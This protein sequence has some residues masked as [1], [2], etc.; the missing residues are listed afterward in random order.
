M[1]PLQVGIV[2]CGVVGAAI[3]YELSGQLN[4]AVT[5]VDQ[6]SPEQWH[7][8]GAALGVLIGALSQKL[9]GRHLQLRWDSLK[10]YETLIPELVALTGE[11]IPY[12]R[13]GILELCFDPA[14]WQRWQ[15][16]ATVRQLQGFDLQ[17]LSRE[18]VAERYPEVG[19]ARS[20]VGSGLTIGGVCSLRD[21]QV[22]PVAL[23]QALIQAAQ[24][25]GANVQFQTQVERIGN[26]QGQVQTLYTSQGSIPVD[27]L[28]VAAGLGSTPLTVQLQSPVEIRPVLGQALHLRR[29]TPLDSPRPVIQAED[30]HLVP[31]NAW[32]LWVGATVEF[33]EAGGLVADAARLEQVRQQAIALCPDLA[34]AQ[35]IRSWSGLRPRPEGRSAPVVEPL[36]GYENVLLATGHYRNGVLLAPITALK[37]LDWIRAATA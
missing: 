25:R 27:W 8:T 19:L 22:D 32:D 7:S 2:G 10:R 15:Q 6:R 4:L 24:L 13:L 28:V 3:A 1:T 26:N 14:D 18:Q 33:A 21:R 12:N 36:N 37:V 29:P 20:L 16:V 23:T 9:K 5:V 17:L 30:V 31:L 35:V 34:T 11:A